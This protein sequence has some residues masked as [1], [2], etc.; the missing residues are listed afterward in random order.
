MPFIRLIAI[1]A[2]IYVFV[3]L[4]KK[5]DSGHARFKRHL[6]LN[7]DATISRMD[8]QQVRFGK[9]FAEYR[10][11]V[12]FTDGF[13]YVTNKTKTEYNTPVKYAYRISV[14]DELRQEIQ[15]DAIACHEKAV[16]RQLSRKR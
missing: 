11:T 15:E 6:E 16:N 10:T 2:L 14:D 5:Y 3:T 4:K 8:S 13:E 9:T 12:E 1:I 7:P